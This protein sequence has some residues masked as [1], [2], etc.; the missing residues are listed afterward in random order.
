MTVHSPRHSY[1]APYKIMGIYSHG[2]RGSLI[3]LEACVAW[4]MINHIHSSDQPIVYHRSILSDVWSK[5]AVY[6]LCDS[7][8]LLLDSWEISMGF[9][10]PILDDIFPSQ[11]LLVTQ[12]THIALSCHE[13]LQ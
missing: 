13:K 10:P 8:S 7:F 4:T 1:P 11:L 6:Y 9:F 3:V 2:K 12:S 5:R